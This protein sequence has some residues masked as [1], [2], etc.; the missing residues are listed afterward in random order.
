VTGAGVP[1]VLLDDLRRRPEWRHLPARAQEL[2]ERHIRSIYRS[3]FFDGPQIGELDRV[4][5]LAEAAPALSEQI[6]DVGVHH[7]TTIAG[8]WL[9]RALDRRL[10]TDL[11]TARPDGSVGYDGVIGP[12]TGQA[13]AEA[14]RRGLAGD[15][16]DDIVDRRIDIMRAL[17]TCAAGRARIARAESFRTVPDLPTPR[18][19]LPRSSPLAVA[20]GQ[21]ERAMVQIGD[22]APDFSLPASGGGN[23]DLRGLRGRKIVL[24]FYPED[25]TPGSAREACGFRDGVPAFQK[26]EAEIIGVSRDSIGRHDEFK[27]KHGLPFALAADEDGWVCKAYGVWVEKSNRGRKYMGIERSTFLIDESGV[28]RDVWRRI[29]VDGHV[30]EVLTA[31]RALPETRRAA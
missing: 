31:A 27:A 14:V 23:V 6:F 25:D 17:P 11:R 1:Q 8:R 22:E 30:N 9:Q 29:G 20:R 5:G 3:E 21:W 4:A 16:N 19:G 10:G 7:G 2:A 13:V 12:R 18:G 28:V 24:Y 15:I 26:V